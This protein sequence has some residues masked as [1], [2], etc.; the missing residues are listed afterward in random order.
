MILKFFT[1]N[2]TKVYGGKAI[3]DFYSVN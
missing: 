1:E 3:Q 2:G